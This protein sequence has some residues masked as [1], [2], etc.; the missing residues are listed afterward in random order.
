MYFLVHRN[1]LRNP[2]FFKKLGLSQVSIAGN[3]NFN[4]WEAA[5]PPVL[6][7]AVMG[8]NARGALRIGGDALVIQWWSSGDPIWCF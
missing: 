8:A 7:N 4:H 5:D 1:F 3:S 2:L 6:S